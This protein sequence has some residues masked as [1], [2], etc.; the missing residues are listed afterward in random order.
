MSITAFDIPT[1]KA[2]LDKIAQRVGDYEWA[3]APQL[4]PD[5]DGW[6]YGMEQNYLKDLCAYWLNDYKWADTVDE[7]NRY[8]HFITRVDD[9]DIHFIR[10]EAST[11]NPRVLLMTHGWPGSVYEFIEVIDRLAHPEKYG[12]KAEDGVTVICPS[13]PGYGFSGKPKRPIGPS[14]TA[15]L[16]DKMMRENL[17]YDR[18]IAQG[19]DWGSLITA[20]LGLDYS[21]AQNGGC[22]A[23]HINFYGM[24]GTEQPETEEE[25]QWAASMVQTMQAEG[26]YLQLQA[27]KPQTLGYGLMDSPVGTCAWI[28]E[29]FHGWADNFAADGTRNIESRFSKHQLLSNVMIYLLTRSFN[30]SIWFYRGFF[31]EMPHIPEGRKIDVPVGV[32]NFAEPFLRFPPRRMIEHSYNVTHWRD[33]DHVGHFAAMEDGAVFTREIQDWLKS[34]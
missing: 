26:A 5:E 31:E 21:P 14:T 2:L 24:R 17:G 22:E 16:W 29:K 7:L 4:G 19:G 11:S 1:D 9:M 34:L 3:Q 23:I 13:M 10:E 32:G 15:K 20:A 28:V 12:G 8:A 18:Y 27:T 33:Y 6:A 30:T 25:K